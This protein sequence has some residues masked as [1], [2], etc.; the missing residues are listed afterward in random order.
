MQQYSGRVSDIGLGRGNRGRRVRGN[1]DLRRKNPT[2]TSTPRRAL[3]DLEE[4]GQRR[5]FGPDDRGAVSVEDVA[6]AV[7]PR[8]K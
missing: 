3:P 2:A 4:Q 5:G 8:F 7:C 6:W 1:P